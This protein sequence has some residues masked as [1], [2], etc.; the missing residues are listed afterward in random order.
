MPRFLLFCL[1]SLPFFCFSQMASIELVVKPVPVPATRN[2]M[3]DQWNFVQPG[4]SKLTPQAQEFLYWVNYCRFEPQ[5]FWDSVLVP[6]AKAFPALSGAEARSLREDLL[7]TGSLPMFAL[8]PKLINTAQAHAYDISR[9]GAAPSH[10]STNGTDFGTRMKNAGI[11]T[12][13]NE[14][15]A[16]SSQ[17]VLLSVLLL[18]LDIGLPERGHRKALLNGSLAVVGVGTAPYGKNQYFIV[19][20]L[21]CIQ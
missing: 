19:Q 4:F 12:C 8:S 1:L 11:K 15:I 7:R 13:A 9:N 2:Q 10:T 3:V 14:N 17:H 16:V 6:V 5:K 20:D 18:Y 21:A